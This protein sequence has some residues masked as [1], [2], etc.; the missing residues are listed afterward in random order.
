MKNGRPDL[1]N[2]ARKKISEK[3][4][5]HSVSKET[6]E[7]LRQSMLEQFR[8][9][10]RIFF[11]P[12]KGKKHTEAA[13]EKMS[14]A[15]K[16]RKVTW[17]D[18]I[19]QSSKKTWKHKSIEDKKKHSENVK[20]A[21]KKKYPNGRN[22]QVAANWQGGLTEKR[23]SKRLKKGS[24]ELRILISEISKGRKFSK[25]TRNKLSKAQSGEKGNNWKGG[26]T[27][28]NLI[29]RSSGEHKSW[30]EAVFARDNWT[31]Q[32]CKKRGGVV[33][34]PHHIQNFAQYSELRFEVSNGI[35]FCKEDHNLF[36]KKYGTE[37]NNKE[38][39]EE[40]LKS[41]CHVGF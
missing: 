13:K 39:L 29:I 19:G 32:K 38:Q 21:L 40:F 3:L 24:N 20:E 30:R 2:E 15:Q 28:K 18:K 26:V 8:S 9:G 7:K 37:N 1:S 33:L 25:E 11:S 4:K 41:I 27:S 22:G 23:I 16:G 5:G 17:G 34:H 6:R 10:K 31:C 35:T 12:L 14:K 36:H